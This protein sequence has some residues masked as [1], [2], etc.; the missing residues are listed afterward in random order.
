MLTIAALYLSLAAMPYAC[1]ASFAVDAHAMGPLTL[2]ENISVITASYN[3]DSLA[4]Q[5]DGNGGV[6]Y[7]VAIC[8]DTNIVAATEGK[9][10]TLTELSTKSPAFV[11][12]KGAHV[13]M[14][15]AELKQLY[16]GG[17]LNV[18]VGEGLVATFDTG[19]GIWFDLDQNV[20]PRRC[21]DYGVNCDAL[22]Q[23]VKT[24]DVF[25]RQS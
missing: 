3:Y 10:T 4:F 5:D 22:I 21:Y 25:I 17:K 2:G 18:L 1:P 9:H 14:N 23:H 8:G 19:F 6:L 7:T 16:P 12:E 11:T 24:V 20:I 13:G 15:V